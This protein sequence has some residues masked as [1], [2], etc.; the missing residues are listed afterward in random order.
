MPATE[1]VLILFATHLA[2]RD[3][4]YVT[5]KVYLSAICQMH[6]SS[7]QL[8]FFNQ[9]LTPRLQQTLKGIQKAQAATHPPKARL[10]I[11][12]D[13]MRDIIRLLSQKPQSYTNIMTW[14]ACCLAFFGFLRVSE[15]TIPSQEQYDKSCHLSLN[16]VSLDNRDNPRMLKISIKQSKTDPF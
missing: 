7:R 4:S 5:I 9:Q 11:T 2:T 10:P 13:I 16:D 15:F 12:L 8:Q 6:V 3:I 1:K 14:A